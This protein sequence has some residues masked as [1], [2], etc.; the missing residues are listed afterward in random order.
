MADKPSRLVASHEPVE[1]ECGRARYVSRGG[2]KLA[3]ALARFGV[4]PTGLRV[5]DAGAST[6]GFTDCLLQAGAASVVAVDVG[7]GQLAHKLR[8]D[9]RV[10]SCEHLDIRHV[11]LAAVGGIPVDMATVDLS[12]ISVVRAIPVLVGEAVRPGGPLL[13]LVKPQFEA[14]RVEASRARGVI[15]DPTP[16]DAPSARWSMRWP[17]PEQPSWG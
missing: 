15:R 6:G 14:G 10:V 12:F 1:L 4:D 9:R 8:L 7:H 17:G 16:T 5:L 2:E 11:T 13:V 3:A